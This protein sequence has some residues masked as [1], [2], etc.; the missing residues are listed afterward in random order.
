MGKLETVSVFIFGG[1]R[2]TADS[3]CSHEIKRRLLLGRKVMTNL[4]SMFKSTDINYFAHKG[5]SSQGYGFS[6]G[7]VWMWEL[8]Y[9]ESECR[10]IDALVLWVSLGLQGYPTS[11]SWGRS[12]LG[13]HW[14]DW[15]WGWLSHTLATWWEELTH[16]KIPWC[17][18]RLRAGGVGDDRGWDSWMASPTQWTWVWVDSGSWWWTRRPGVLWFMGSQRVGH[19]WATELNWTE[20]LYSIYICYKILA[21]F[22]VVYFIHSSLYLLNFYPNLVLPH[23][24]LPTANS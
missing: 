15:C 11:P 12:V 13:V 6:S 4:D 23:S 18:K 9:K 17:W 20:R 16:W 5:L 1:S 10:R 7:H 21:T 19:D 24:T 3:D 8:D 2:I 22:L 14:K